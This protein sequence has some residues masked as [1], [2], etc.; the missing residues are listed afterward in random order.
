MIKNL[1]L[2]FKIL[3]SFVFFFVLFSVA[4]SAE[5]AILYL[6]PQSETVYKGES[7]VAG[8]MIDTE[9]EDINA[10]DVRVTFQNN[11]IK[12]ND[13]EKG[14]SIFTL[15]AE[16]PNIRE[17]EISFSAGV[18]GG[19]SGKGLIGR[20]NFSGKEIGEVE[21]NFKKDSKVLLNDGMGTLTE[22]GFA[23]GNYKIVEKSGDLPIIT[24]KSHPDPNKWYSQKNL[25]LWWDLA[26]GAEYSYLLSLSPSDSP[27]EI[28]DKPK[29]ELEWMGA[30]E[31]K[32]LDEGIYYFSLKQKLSGKN[33]SPKVGFRA[34]IDTTP[35]EEFKPEIA[36]IEGK[37]YLVFSTTDKISGVD[38]Y[39]IATLNQV[40]IFLNAKPKI[41]WK[42]GKN[43]YLL[44]DQNLSKIFV[45][46][47][48]KAGN[49][50][51]SEIT[52]PSKPFPYWIIPVIVICLVIIGWIIFKIIREKK[53]KTHKSTQM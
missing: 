16:E 5:A 47:I 19:F 28:P 46:A 41:E 2:K 10:V 17:G 31:Y 27:D 29:G 44:G 23:E 37:K 21:I 4:V 33:W 53:N 34:M 35:P 11:L 52:L 50:Q 39:E 36:E 7:F 14:G 49:E 1:F 8:L 20:I 3:C 6:L 9:G 32:G 51:I 40:G 13:F 38:H 43:P 25:N 15:W 26:K 24:S 22:L 18:P 42:V 48:D 30:I 45:K 12:V